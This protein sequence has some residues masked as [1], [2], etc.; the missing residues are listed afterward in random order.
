MMKIPFRKK[1]KISLEDLPPIV[2]VFYNSKA[3]GAAY[4]NPPH[5][6]RRIWPTGTWMQKRREDLKKKGNQMIPSDF[7]T[8]E[9]V[10]YIPAHAH[11]NMSHPDVE[12][13]IVVSVNDSY[14]FVRFGAQGISKACYSWSLAKLHR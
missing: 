5:R 14:V 2:R 3:N 12:Y 8:G 13:G 1:R 11:G 7:K 6:H 4:S 10:A 9:E